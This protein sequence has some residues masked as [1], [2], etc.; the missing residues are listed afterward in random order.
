[1]TEPSFLDADGLPFVIDRF[2]L[3]G[4]VPSL[5]AFLQA[6]TAGTPVPID[7]A[8]AGNRHRQGITALEVVTFPSR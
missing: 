2:R 4:V 7:T 6:D 5:E 3:D 8:V 1:M